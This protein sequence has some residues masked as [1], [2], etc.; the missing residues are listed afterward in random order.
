MIIYIDLTM[1]ASTPETRTSC[2]S[3]VFLVLSP[4][5]L[6]CEDCEKA[7]LNLERGGVSRAD[8]KEK[9]IRRN[10]NRNRSDQDP[11]SCF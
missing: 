1:S 8:G 9:K 2:C 3:P 7:E 10:R 4:V 5:V 6:D 11:L